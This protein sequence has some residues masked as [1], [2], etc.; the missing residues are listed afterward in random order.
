MAVTL[1]YLRTRLGV[2]PSRVF[3][4]EED[5][6]FY[7]FSHQG[8][9]VAVN[10]QLQEEGDYVRFRIPMLL[11]LTEVTDLPEFL[12]KLLELNY[13]YKLLKFSCDPTDGEVAV[14]IE[15]PVEDSTLTERQLERCLHY[16]ANLALQERDHLR[17][18]L[19]TGVYPSSE[20]MNFTNTLSRLLGDEEAPA[21]E[22]AS[23]EETPSLFDGG[24]HSP[25]P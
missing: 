20:D 2:A 16:I 13:R 8:Q 14:S 19:A 11:N 12:M 23:E 25:H 9:M 3:T 6:L 7:P 21:E 15:L 22:K 24:E 18:F 4:N 1:E 10:I 17:S 5:T